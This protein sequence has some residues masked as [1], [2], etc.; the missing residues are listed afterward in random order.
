MFLLVSLKSIFLL[1]LKK[2]IFNEINKTVLDLRF[3]NPGLL[4]IVIRYCLIAYKFALK[5]RINFTY[6]VTIINFLFFEYEKNLAET[7]EKN[8]KTSNYLHQPRYQ[9]LY[10]I[11]YWFTVAIGAHTEPGA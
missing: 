2:S 10:E 4:V 5:L 7:N 9:L 11:D 6:F 1:I 8:E 3:Y